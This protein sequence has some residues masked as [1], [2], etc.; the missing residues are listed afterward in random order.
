MSYVYASDNLQY[1]GVKLGIFFL[2][3]IEHVTLINSA[4]SSTL[5]TCSVGASFTY[6]I[7]WKCCKPLDW[8]S[9]RQK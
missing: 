6:N 2:S 1:D 4:T 9:R 3:G 5:E 8:Y 7:R